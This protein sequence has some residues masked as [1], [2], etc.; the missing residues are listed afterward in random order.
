MFEVIA[1]EL[2]VEIDEKRTQRLEALLQIELDALLQFPEAHRAEE[3]GLRQ[4]FGQRRASVH[5]TREVDA[6]QETEDVTQLV[7]DHLKQNYQ[8]LWTQARSKILRA[9]KE[10]R[11]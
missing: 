11:L 4:S 2:S 1:V 9:S 10:F 6:V 8:L 5:G 3:H 7:R